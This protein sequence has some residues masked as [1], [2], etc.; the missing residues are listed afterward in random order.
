MV[1]E[2]QLL[3]PTEVMMHPE[4]LGRAW[5]EFCDEFEEL[6]CSAF[7]DRVVDEWTEM[8]EAEEDMET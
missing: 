5:R 2:S 1:R 4:T 7:V 6:W 3:E 8:K